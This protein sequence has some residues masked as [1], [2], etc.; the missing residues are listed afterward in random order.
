M[1]EL[2]QLKEIFARM[3]LETHDISGPDWQEQVSA[4]RA[5]TWKRACALRKCRY[6]DPPRYPREE[7][8][9]V[10][11][12]VTCGG[13]IGVKHE[14]EGGIWRWRPCDRQ[15]RWN[16][17]RAELIKEERERYERDKKGAPKKLIE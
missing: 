2:T 4:S 16:R 8:R 5:A 10:D 3:G 11:A 17:E 9:P 7:P 14:E 6:M 13:Y 1:S 15:M 12:T